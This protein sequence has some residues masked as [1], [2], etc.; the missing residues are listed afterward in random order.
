MGL[1]HAIHALDD[2]WL[3][4]RD[5]L[6]TAEFDRLTGLVAAFTGE[7]IPA[8][9]PVAAMA[10]PRF[11]RRVLPDGHP[12]LAALEREESRFVVEHD[13]VVL[14]DWLDLAHRLRW[15]LLGAGRQP[16]AEEVVEGA[17]RWLLAA[18]AYDEA[19]LRAWDQDPDDPDLVRLQRVDGSGQW[20]EFQFGPDHA[21]L[22]LVRAVNRILEVSDDPW[23][24][25]DWWLGAHEQLAAAPAALI[26]RVEPQVLIAA[27]VA[28]RAGGMSRA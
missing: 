18:P 13:P 23:G 12:V 1:R 22:E 19:Q 10:I 4:V 25:A 7:A 6:S 14:A 5:R 17:C 26:G 8:R 11:L 3:D 15:R 28:E 2:H 21:V 16:T 9:S 24:V 20:P 27:A